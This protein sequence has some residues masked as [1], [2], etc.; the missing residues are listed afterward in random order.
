MILLLAGVAGI[1]I[2]VPEAVWDL[3]DG[4]GGAAT[5]LL[6]TGA[7]LLTASAAGIRVRRH[8]PPAGRPPTVR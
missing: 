4:A 5:V 3:T 6:V 1:S 7:A 2:A 8:R